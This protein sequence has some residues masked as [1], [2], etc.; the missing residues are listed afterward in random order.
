[1]SREARPSYE[2]GP[3]RLDL[4]EQMLFRDGQPLPLTPKVF[5]VLRVLVQ[6]SG[7][8]VEK[9]RVL[10]KEIWPDSFVEEAALNKSVSLLRKALGERLLGTASTSRRR[11]REGIASWRP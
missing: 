10:L 11:R 7:H 9:E 4:A 8:L 2:F 1:M 5:D 3:F 6:N